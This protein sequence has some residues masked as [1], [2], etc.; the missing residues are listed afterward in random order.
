MRKLLQKALNFSLFDLLCSCQLRICFIMIFSNSCFNTNC[1]L[2]WNLLTNNMRILSTKA[3]ERTMQKGNYKLNIPGMTWAKLIEKIILQ[4]P[5]KSPVY[6]F[7][8]STHFWLSRWDV[9]GWR[10]IEEPPCELR[11]RRWIRLFLLFGRPPVT[12]ADLDMVFTDRIT[13]TL[14]IKK[15]RQSKQN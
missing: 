6:I 3:N 2:S 15:G 7:P 14:S 9:C 1:W 5:R 12:E 8:K 11:R 10:L 4:K 13:K